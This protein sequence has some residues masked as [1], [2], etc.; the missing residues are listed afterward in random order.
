MEIFAF[1]LLPLFN[2]YSICTVFVPVL[3]KVTPYVYVGSM[4]GVFCDTAGLRYIN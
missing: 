4:F 2:V 3:W 1:Y